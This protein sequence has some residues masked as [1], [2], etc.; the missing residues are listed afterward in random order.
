MT[1]ARELFHKIGNLHNKICVG[2]GLANAEL[3]RKFANPLPEE[4]EK[5][6]KKFSEIEQFAVEASKDLKQLKETIYKMIDC[7]PDKAKKN[8]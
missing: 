1:D 5:V 2:A 7:P 6:S 3:K 8:D 4:I